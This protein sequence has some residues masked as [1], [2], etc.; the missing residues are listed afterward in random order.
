MRLLLFFGLGLLAA[1]G[2]SPRA[3]ATES[4]VPGCGLANSYFCGVWRPSGKGSE[5]GGRVTIENGV[6]TWENKDRAECLLLDEGERA[7]RPYAAFRCNYR[8]DG[9]GMVE[10]E[11]V[12]LY[13]LPASPAGSAIATPMTGLNI[14]IAD[15]LDCLFSGWAELIKN[16][17]IRISTQPESKFCGITT[18][19]YFR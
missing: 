5:A 9:D 2:L 8:Y 13:P 17:S 14:S 4:P 12:L 7:D 11:F 3:T 6:W 10:Q 19:I 16:N 15:K 1:A 18:M